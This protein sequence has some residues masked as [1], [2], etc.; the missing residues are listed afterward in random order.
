MNTKILKR[1]IIVFC[2]AASLIFGL[3]G[4]GAVAGTVIR[5]N[6]DSGLKQ[7]DPIWTTAY[8]VRSHSFLVYDTLFGLDKDFM[9]QPQMVD[10][11]SIS[12]DGLLYSFTLRDG[13][14][15]HDGTAV[16]S[17]DCV[18]SIKR[19]GAKDGLG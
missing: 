7:L 3:T 5:V 9:V 14:K 13:L 10:R 17:K 15:W 2:L 16:T 11:Y 8:I 1:V 4:P 6:L 18:A 19:W 12:D